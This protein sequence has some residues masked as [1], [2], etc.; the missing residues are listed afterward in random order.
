MINARQL[1]R[2]EALLADAHDK[3][4]QVVALAD[5][6]EARRA[7]KLA[8]HLVLNVRD[9]MQIMQEEIFG[10]LLPVL[11]YRELEQALDYINA[12]ERPLALYLFDEDDARVEQVLRKTLSGGVSVNTVMLHVLQE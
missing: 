6:E 12:H 5:A 2:V 10:P 11:A 7:G 8:P 3:G 4:A 9:D 1:A